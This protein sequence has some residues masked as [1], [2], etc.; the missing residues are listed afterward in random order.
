MWC[1][2][3][4]LVVVLF[5]A[6]SLG[7]L[8]RERVVLPSA[9]GYATRLVVITSPSDENQVYMQTSADT[10]LVPF[11]ELM[12]DVHFFR[13]GPQTLGLSEPRNMP[14]APLAPALR[15]DLSLALQDGEFVDN[16]SPKLLAGTGLTPLSFPGGSLRTP[17]Q[18]S[19]ESCAA[20]T[21]VLA[22]S[23]GSSAIS[24]EVVV[25]DSVG[26]ATRETRPDRVLAI[27]QSDCLGEVQLV[28]VVEQATAGA[29]T[30][31]RVSKPE[32]AE[33]LVDDRELPKNVSQ[34]AVHVRCGDEPVVAVLVNGNVSTTELVVSRRVGKSWQADPPIWVATAGLVD[35]G[36]SSL[37]WSMDTYMMGLISRPSAPDP[38]GPTFSHSDKTQGY[39]LAA[40]RI[41]EVD[42]LRG[43][44]P[45]LGGAISWRGPGT[46]AG[47][48][49]SSGDE[50]ATPVVACSSEDP[51]VDVA[52]LPGR[53]AFLT[54]NGYVGTFTAPG[55]CIDVLEQT[56]DTRKYQNAT[57]LFGLG[58]GFAVIAASWEETTAADE[59]DCGTPGCLSPRWTVEALFGVAGVDPEI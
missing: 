53:W 4:C 20:P 50:A 41:S 23:E 49:I 52:R 34:A 54:E 45:V 6:T 8:R 19:Q 21:L 25:F 43:V 2:N 40:G 47:L 46:P 33:W 36:T 35:F 58:A 59:V 37:A 14:D 56:I 18:I 12:V 32:A 38:T 15:P 3:L 44:A 9:S 31:V 10:L 28:R 48:A 1:R 16:D 51:I 57:H 29:S 17:P 7:C 30:V 55:P 11:E 24:T 22:E 26:R 27:T 42:G 39:A 13:C 5:G